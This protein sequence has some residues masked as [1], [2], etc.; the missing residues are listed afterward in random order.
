MYRSNLPHH[1]L[2][3]CDGDCF[4]DLCDECK[5]YIKSSDDESCSG[6]LPCPFSA[7][8]LEV[9]SLDVNPFSLKRESTANLYS[10]DSS[11]ENSSSEDNDLAHY[12]LNCKRKLVTKQAELVQKDFQVFSETLDC[13]DEQLVQ[14]HR[15]NSHCCNLLSTF[16]DF[17]QS[18]EEETDSTVNCT[19]WFVA[20]N[21]MKYLLGDFDEESEELIQRLKN[22]MKRLYDFYDGETKQ[23]LNG[24]QTLINLTSLSTQLLFVAGQIALAENELDDVED[25]L[26]MQVQQQRDLID[27]FV[28]VMASIVQAVQTSL[29]H[30]QISEFDCFT[31]RHFLQE[32][33]KTLNQIQII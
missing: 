31:G 17:L 28:E 26:Q 8:P 16:E 1:N 5:F 32:F 14:L 19:D 25:R 15:Q 33:D 10:T 20:L 30:N 9:D 22:K 24:H 21:L 27:Q 29:E 12:E 4:D 23:V 6:S 18:F 7:S 11:S 2:K 3:S 13:L